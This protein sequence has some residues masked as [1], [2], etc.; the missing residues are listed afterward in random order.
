LFGACLSRAATREATRTAPLSSTFQ[1]RNMGFP[2]LYD[3]W[4]LRCIWHVS[5]FASK[6]L[7]FADGLLIRLGFLEV[8]FCLL[9]VFPFFVCLF[10][11][12][13]RMK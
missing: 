9:H 12:P 13:T 11:L 8:I 3:C 2:R 7:Y 1:T 6:S 10:Q 4:S 5:V